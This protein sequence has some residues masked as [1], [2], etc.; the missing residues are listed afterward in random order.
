MLGFFRDRG[1]ISFAYEVDGNIYNKGL[2]LM[3]T[4]QT[5]VLK[6]ATL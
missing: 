2:A 3:K 1:N 6:K 5:R 4:K